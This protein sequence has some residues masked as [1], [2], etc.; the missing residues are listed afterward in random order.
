M[1]IDAT[2][3]PF[4]QRAIVTLE[5]LT[6]IDDE[7]RWRLLVVEIILVQEGERWLVAS[8]EVLA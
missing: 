7:S 3:T 1:A 2:E 8:L 6:T 4:G 5:E